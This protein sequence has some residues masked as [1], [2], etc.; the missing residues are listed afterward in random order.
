MDNVFNSIVHAVLEG[1]NKIGK[2]CV[3]ILLIMS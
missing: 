3:I 1:F 2:M